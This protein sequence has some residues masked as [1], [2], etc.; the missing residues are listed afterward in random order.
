MGGG[1]AACGDRGLRGADAPVRVID[2]FVDEMNISEVRFGRY[3]PAATGRPPYDLRD[4][5]KLYIGAIQS[6]ELL[7]ALERACCRKIE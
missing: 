7:A 6:S 4:L 5:L 1:V 3:V 2:A